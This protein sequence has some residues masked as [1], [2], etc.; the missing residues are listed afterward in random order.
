MRLMTW[1][2]TA[3]TLAGMFLV[4]PPAP[5]AEYRVSS[6]DDIARLTNTL[7]PGDVLVMADGTWTD[8]AVVFRGRGTPDQPITLRAQTPGRVVLTGASSLKIDGE[9]LVVSGLWL[10]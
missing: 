7:R 10:K 6:A 1:N 9:H 8:Q 2:G 4:P 3:L 5:A